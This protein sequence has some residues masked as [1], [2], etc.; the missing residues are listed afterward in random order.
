MGKLLTR[1]PRLT[2]A[3]LRT[4]LRSTTGGACRREIEKFP[5]TRWDFHMFV[6]CLCLQGGGVMVWGGGTVSFSS[7][8]ITGNTASYVRAH[9]QKFPSPRWENADVLALILAFVHLRL[10]L[11]ST[12]VCTCRRDLKSSHRP[13]GNF[14]CFALVLAGR[15]CLSLEWHGDLLIVHRNWQHSLQCAC[16]RS[17]FPS[18]RWDFHI[19]GTC[20]CLQG[21]GVAVR[22]GTVTFSSCTITGNTASGSVRALVQSFPSP[23]WENC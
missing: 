14:T 15:R 1:L 21:G 10:T 16:S 8:S 19:F 11:R 4:T 12:S 17:N 5:S 7:C 20:L 9:A 13:D 3:Q 2:L 23:R 22:D 6:A 18:P